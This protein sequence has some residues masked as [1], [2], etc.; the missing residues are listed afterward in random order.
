MK[1]VIA[2]MIGT[3]IGA[4]IAWYFTKEKCEADR[5]DEIDQLREYYGAKLSEPKEESTQKIEKNV[6][7]AVEE[8]PDIA[9]YSS[10]LFN[11]EYTDYSR[12]AKKEKAM[13]TGERPYVISPDEF[14]EVEDY[15]QISLMYYADGVLCDDMDVPVDNVDEVV[16]ADFASHFGEYE[17]DSV[18]V[19][20]D[21]RK[22]DYEILRSLRTYEEI[23]AENPYKAGVE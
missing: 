2:F 6:H 15:D 3:G 7:S 19:R 8:K 23:I 18:F 9:I 22:C 21:P 20:N 17:D 13:A 14:G 12:T 4:A 1:T 5:R 11:T 10:Y 16:G